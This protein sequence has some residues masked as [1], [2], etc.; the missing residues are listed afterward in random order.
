MWGPTECLTVG[1]LSGGVGNIEKI[2]NCFTRV[3]IQVRD[4]GKITGEAQTQLKKLPLVKGLLIRGNEIQL[5]IGVEAE[6]L[7]LE[8]NKHL[9]FTKAEC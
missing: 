2:Y 1:I 9:G 5:V 8:C 4:L 3:H 6:K 7:S